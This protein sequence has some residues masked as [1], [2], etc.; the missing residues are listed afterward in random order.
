MAH[1]KSAKKR[2]KVN[3]RRRVRNRQYISSSRTLVRRAEAAIAEG[4]PEAAQ[5]AVQR[6]ISALDRSVSKGI[7]HAN[8]AARRKSRLMSKYNAMGASE[9]A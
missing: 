8:N 2:I 1:T 5:E 3:E 6:A 9:S 7:V 4:D